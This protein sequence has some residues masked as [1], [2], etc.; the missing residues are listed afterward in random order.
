MKQLTFRILFLVATA[1]VGAI[2]ACQNAASEPAG[3]MEQSLVQLCA[4]QEVFV[5]DGACDFH[6][7]ETCPGAR[8]LMTCEAVPA[9]I[10]H[11]NDTRPTKTMYENDHK[12]VVVPLGYLCLDL[13]LRMS[14]DNSPVFL[15]ADY[16]D[17]GVWTNVRD[18]FLFMPDVLSSSG[19]LA[20]MSAVRKEWEKEYRRNRLSFKLAEPRSVTASGGQESV[21]GDWKLTA[22][23][24]YGEVYGLDEKQTATWIGATAHYSPELARFD[25]PDGAFVLYCP[26]RTPPPEMCR[27]PSYSY[28]IVTPKK[29]DN[30]FG[31][32][33]VTLGLL[34]RNIGVVEVSDNTGHWDCPGSCLIVKSS[35]K[36]ITLWDGVYFELTRMKGAPHGY[37]HQ[38]LTRP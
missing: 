31:V 24:G 1:A 32:D 20:Q 29:F 28:E 9:L 14:A 19:G 21:Y 11:L 10:A 30:E 7:Q 4:L 26:G 22:V 6:V 35:D 34:Q 33:R 17:D 25:F 37:E 15:A 16:G 13:L 18:N 38:P 2:G 5:H 3:P 23:A 8:E 36:L 27:K 12:T